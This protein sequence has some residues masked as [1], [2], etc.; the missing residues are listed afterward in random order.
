MLLSLENVDDSWI[1]DF[2]VSFYA[3]LY[4]GYF[5]DYV[6]EDFGLVPCQ[7]VRKGKIKIELQNENH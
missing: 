2:G 3:T 6:Q 5:L 1:L 4:R 7:I